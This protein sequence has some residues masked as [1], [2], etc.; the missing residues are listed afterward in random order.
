MSRVIHF[1]QNLSLDITAGA[2]V[3]SFF[4]AHL[5]GVALTVSMVIGLAIAIWLIHTLDHLK[6]AV[7]SQLPVLNPRHAFHRKYI[8]ELIIGV[9]VA[10]GLGL[11]NLFRLPQRTI[12]F[13]SVLVILV[14]LYFAYLHFS[15]HSLRKEYLA[16]LIYTAGVSLAPLSLAEQVNRHEM[17]VILQIFLLA[18]VNLM[19]IPLYEFSLDLSDGQFSIVTQRG[20]RAVRQSAI[21]LLV[22]VLLMAFWM[23]ASWPA[24]FYEELVLLAMALV[25][26]ILLAFQRLFG[27][28]QLYRVL[29]DGIFFLPLILWL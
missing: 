27:R 19:V 20:K 1:V 8:K 13:G 28:Y 24:I 11:W 17:L 4:V 16:A 23:M 18:L 26:V 14:A 6:D 22:L 2:V 12:L 10:F 25:L 7:H 3:M 9:L 15:K 29:A 5:L 21:V